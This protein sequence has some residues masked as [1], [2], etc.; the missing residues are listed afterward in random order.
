M[1]IYVEHDV[2]AGACGIGVVSEFDYDDDGRW[3]NDNLLK[4]TKGGTGYLCAGF[5]KD[6]L[7]CDEVFTQLSKKYK[8]VFVS[9]CRKN[10]NSG[11]MFYF[12]VFDCKGVPKTKIGYIAMG[13]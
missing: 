4:G 6:D 13:H 5:I 11:N 12:A 2:V 9:E 10:V 1:T 3:S 8:V 7:I